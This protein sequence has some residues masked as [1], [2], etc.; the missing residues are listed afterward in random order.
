MKNCIICQKEIPARTYKGARPGRLCGQK[1]CKAELSR[2]TIRESFSKHGGEITKFRK[3]N[4]M[5]DPVVRETVSTKLRAMGWKPKVRM[6]NGKG[7]TIHQLAIASALGWEMEVA[8]PTKM[9]RSDR[10][11]PTCY[12]VDV[13]N[14]LLKI[15]IEVDGPSH[16]AL[17]RQ[18]QDKKKDEFLKS[19]GWKV[20]RFKNKQVAEHLEECVQTVLSTI[21]KSQT[22]TPI[23]PTDT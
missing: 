6:G 17:K 16:Y 15:A 23:S 22:E 4:G 10:L 18:E 14:A 1:E 11:Y 13:G 21:S 7:P 12:K 2:R 9:N 8:I 20:L 5:K 3:T 19:I